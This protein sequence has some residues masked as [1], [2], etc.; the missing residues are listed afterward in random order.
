MVKNI[1]KELL[2]LYLNALSRSRLLASL[3]ILM[4]ALPALYFATKIQQDSSTERFIVKSDVGI[5][6]YET[7]KKRFGNDEGMV[8][9]LPAD[10][11][12]HFSF[13]PYQRLL[14]SLQKIPV[15]TKIYSPFDKYEA[16]IKNADLPALKKKVENNP[17]EEKGGL[18]SFKE[19]YIAFLLFVDIATPS[20]RT[21][22]FYRVNE[23]IYASGFKPE[24]AAIG[25][26]PV[27]NHFLGISPQESM[28]IFLPILFVLSAVFLYFFL[29]SLKGILL[30]LTVVGFTE[31]FTFGLVGFAGGVFDMLSS[32]LPVVLYIVTLAGAIHILHHCFTLEYKN[33]E[34]YEKEVVQVFVDKF[35]PCLFS[36]FTT[37]AGF[38]SLFLSS[39]EPVKFLGLYLSW[40]VAISFFVLYTLLPLLCLVFVP[41]KSKRRTDYFYQK[42]I[43]SL[44]KISSGSTK[45]VLIF[46]LALI[47]LAIA[48]SGE[49]SFQTNGLLYFK[50]DSYVRVNT[51]K[52]EHAGFGMSR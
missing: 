14:E 48:V 32:I 15:I 21:E 11:N 2:P 18:I 5:A 13:A 49:I 46:A 22:L 33:R 51:A 16:L 42:V 38:A 23:L 28:K 52:L 37:A 24:I 27:L 31:L 30:P 39:V 6:K 17:F 43:S 1:Q 50:K 10:F 45:T 7:F 47:A 12:K 25:G 34:Q 36:S 44:L 9:L 35:N 41:L 4:L 20:G 19:K 26:E 8:I 40:G 29:G 3:I